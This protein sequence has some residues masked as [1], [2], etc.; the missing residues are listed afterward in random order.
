MM[1][2]AERIPFCYAKYSKLMKQYVTLMPKKLEYYKK[3]E[4]I[5]R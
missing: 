5:K 1:A 4:K 2:R 3:D